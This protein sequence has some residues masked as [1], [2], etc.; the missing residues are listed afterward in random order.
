MYFSSNASEEEM[1]FFVKDYAQEFH[2]LYDWNRATIHEKLW[3]RVKFT[4]TTKMNAHGLG[5][6]DEF[7]IST[8]V[9]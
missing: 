2:F 9:K 8:A 7:Q 1:S 3:V 5:D 6:L 4:D